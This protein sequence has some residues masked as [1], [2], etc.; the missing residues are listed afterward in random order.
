M[1]KLSAAQI[2]TL[3]RQAGFSS[4]KKVSGIPQDVLAVAVA[5]AESGGDTHA[6]NSKPPDNSYGLWQINMYGGLGPARRRQLNL[7]SNEQLFDAQT[8]AR[9]AFHVSNLGTSFTPWSVYKSGAFIKHLPAAKSGTGNP[10]N[11]PI[12]SDRFPELST[13]PGGVV[14]SITKWVEGQA[15]RVGLF[16]G[17]GVLLIVG[18]VMLAKQSGAVDKAIS[19]IPLAK[20]AKRVI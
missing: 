1:A 18:V 5:L 8:N 14:G 9:A 6:H 17:G 2:A 19:A 4:T 15:F 10:A 20:V 3:A 7:K 16:I 12:Q 11:L 13:V